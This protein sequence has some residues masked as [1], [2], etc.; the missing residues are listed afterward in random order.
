M[1]QRITLGCLLAAMLFL[2]LGSIAGMSL[3]FGAGAFYELAHWHRAKQ[4]ARTP[5]RIRRR[6]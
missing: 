4:K 2:A 1:P 5:I 3:A 6:S